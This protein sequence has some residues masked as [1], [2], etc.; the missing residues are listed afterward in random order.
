MREVTNLII[1]TPTVQ[2]GSWV[3]LRRMTFGEHKRALEA[4]KAARASGD[5]EAIVEALFSN[6]FDGFVVSVGEMYNRDGKP[7]ECT[8]D[9]IMDGLLDGEYNAFFYDVLLAH[10]R[11]DFVVSME[12]LKN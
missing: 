2:P 4:F 11:G 10:A 1:Q 7:I 8:R 6:V 5:T 3:E 9:G 12:E